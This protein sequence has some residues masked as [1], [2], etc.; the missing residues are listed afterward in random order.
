M[1]VAKSLIANNQ[2]FVAILM[3]LYSDCDA[4]EGGIYW[5]K[6]LFYGSM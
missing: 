4:E 5:L 6:N 1:L 2:R 3:I